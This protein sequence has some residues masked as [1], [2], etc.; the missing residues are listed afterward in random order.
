MVLNTKSWSLLTKGIKSAKEAEAIAEE[1]D[2]LLKMIIYKRKRE[3]IFGSFS[4][5]YL[6]TLKN[7]EK[8]MRVWRQFHEQDKIK[9][10]N[11]VKML[12]KTKPKAPID[13]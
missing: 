9:N 7:N 12:G 6:L 3:A 10:Q 1:V 2:E 13:R 4:V 8:R 5:S 11:K